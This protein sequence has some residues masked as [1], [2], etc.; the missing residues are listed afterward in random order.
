MNR[1]YDVIVIGAGNGGLAAAAGL[2]KTGLKTLVVEKHN[3]PGGAATSFVRGRFEFEPSLHELALI[4]PKE[5]PGPMRQIFDELGADIDWICD[6]EETF[7]L[8][9][10]EEGI[11]AYMPCGV[12]AFA[13]KMEELVP[14]SFEST[15]KFLQIGIQVIQAAPLFNDP[16]ATEEQIEAACPNLFT[17]LGY[18]AREGFEA[19]GMPEK[20]QRILS[21]Y[22]CY[23]G[24]TTS[25]MGFAEYAQ[26]TVVF[27][28]F[29]A[30]AAKRRSHEISLALDKVIRDNG[31]EIWYNTEAERILVKDGKAYGVQIG[32]KEYYAG[33]VVSNAYPDLVYGKMIDK[34]EVP[35]RA[36]KL[37]NSRQL[38][39]KFITIYLGMNKTAEE[40]GIDKYSTFISTSSDDDK[41]FEMCCD[42]HDYPNYV[43]CNCLNL[44]NPDCT[45][46]GTCQLFLTV[47]FYGNGWNDVTADEYFDL[48]DKIALDAIHHVERAMEVELVPYIEEIEVA[49]PVT[50]ARY[51]NTPGGTPYGYQM[52]KEDDFRNRW[53]T[54]K[55]ETFIDDLVFVGAAAQDGDG[56]NVA[57]QNGLYAAQLIAGKEMQKGGKVR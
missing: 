7:R 26:L 21:T 48:K 16:T 20:A 41:Q 54:L 22:W 49:S 36:I 10:P 38:G 56:F 18:T 32:G 1:D 9:V 4:G 28:L 19:L 17:M 24:G 5:N 37:V 6:M 57:Y 13:K 23:L 25:V 31:G 30:G 34:K 27:V 46:E 50:F 55:E 53:T 14:G 44:I 51:L 35:E 3:I 12:E 15:L 33:Y 47:T 2:A 40:L 52:T 42:T 43:I 11:D 8:L 29:G 39:I 45:P